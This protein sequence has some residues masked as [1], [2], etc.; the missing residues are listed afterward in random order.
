MKNS[1]NI[2]WNIKSSYYGHNVPKNFSYQI[3][4]YRFNS[5]DD[6][7][8]EDNYKSELDKIVKGIHELFYNIPL[9]AF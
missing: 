6:S 9:L 4:H 7:N 3:E 5:D 1:N 8:S 2:S